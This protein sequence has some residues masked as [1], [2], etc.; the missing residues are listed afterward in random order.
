MFSQIIDTNIINLLLLQ[1]NSQTKRI[2]KCTVKIVGI[3][4][5]FLILPYDVFVLLNKKLKKTRRQIII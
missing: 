4:F 1:V 3:I 5:C 2:G